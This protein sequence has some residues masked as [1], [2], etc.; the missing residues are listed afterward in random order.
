MFPLPIDRI[1]NWIK[2]K[3]SE[4]ITEQVLPC[5]DLKVTDVWTATFPK[6]LS[7]SSIWTIDI[8]KDNIEDVIFGYGTALD[9]SLHPDIF[10]PMFMEFSPPC[11]GGVIALNGLNG[12]VLW[13]RGLTHSVFS[14]ICS[15][16][17]NGDG[18]QDC[19]VTGKG[20]VS[21]LRKLKNLR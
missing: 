15:H 16:D 10:C 13:R 21:I 12:E 6:L 11:E 5:S 19:L 17:I 9:N 2:F 3:T 8:N 14:I 1:K 4:N 7:E 20:G 18:L